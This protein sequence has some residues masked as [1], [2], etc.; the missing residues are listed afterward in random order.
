[1]EKIKIFIF[2]KCGPGPEEIEHKGTGLLCNPY[3]INDVSEQIIW[4]LSHKKE[5]E[6]IAERG[7][8]FVLDSFEEKKITKKN[9][10][11]YNHI[12]NN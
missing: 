5:C 7:R 4:A 8:L 9:T 10:D 6:S 11:F 3:D 12:I 2:Y 1:M